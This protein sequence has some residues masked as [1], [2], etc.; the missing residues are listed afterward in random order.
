MNSTARL[1]APLAGPFLH[2]HND[3]TSATLYFMFS[4][5]SIIL[6][7][8]TRH[9]VLG[10]VLRTPPTP[11]PTTPAVLTPCPRCQHITD[12]DL[13]PP[14]AP[15]NEIPQPPPAEPPLTY[16]EILAADKK[17]LTVVPTIP[18]FI[19]CTIL[20]LANITT[21]ILIAFAIQALLY[22]STEVKQSKP[23]AKSDTQSSAIILWIL[24]AGISVAWA[25]SGILCWPIWVRNLWIGEEAAEKWPIRTDLGGMV[26]LG[27]IFGPIFLVILICMAV[28]VI[29]AGI[30][31]G[32]WQSIRGKPLAVVDGSEA[33]KGLGC[34]SSSSS[35]TEVEGI[36]EK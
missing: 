9:L 21:L 3:N 25:S 22:C 4:L 34:E 6:T 7:C 18:R 28:V 35:I 30:I 12:A 24:Y 20:T 14:S 16:E 1:C 10:Y 27:V 36:D 2:V 32:L 26:L 33:E 29:P 19:F 8:F 15:L 31:K 23:V 13:P 5:L 17:R 11:T